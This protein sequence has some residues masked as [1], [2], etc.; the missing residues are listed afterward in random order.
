[1]NAPAS[2]NVISMIAQMA[3]MIVVATRA[4]N[5]AVFQSSRVIPRVYPGG[6][7]EG[8]RATASPSR[9]HA[10]SGK[11]PGMS[12]TVI[13]A[14]LGM[15]FAALTLRNMN[16]RERLSKRMAVALIVVLAAYPL[17]LGPACW[18]SSLTGRGNGAVSAIYEPLIFDGPKFAS[19]GF[20][21]YSQWGAEKGWYWRRIS[22]GWQ[23]FP[24]PGAPQP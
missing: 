23:N 7:G 20:Q 2:Q 12:E 9:P 5:P 15:A 21:W 18:I 11:M 24:P 8:E 1:V 6:L 17:S 10:A 13:F 14:T 16:H 22:G 4:T 19:R 3:A